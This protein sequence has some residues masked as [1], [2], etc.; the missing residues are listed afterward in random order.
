ML[1]EAYL[2]SLIIIVAGFVA[3]MLCSFFCCILNLLD[4]VRKF[5]HQNNE[6]NRLAIDS[7]IEGQESI[8]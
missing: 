6:P 3:Y 1:F 7:N 5:W 4:R 8:V 2:W